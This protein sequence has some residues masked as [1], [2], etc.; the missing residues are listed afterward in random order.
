MSEVID[1]AAGKVYTVNKD[2]TYC[3]VKFTV[4]WLPGC[5]GFTEQAK[6]ALAATMG[7]DK[8]IIRGNYSILG[9]SRDPLIQEG[10]ALKRLL[11]T[12]RDTYTIPEYTLLSSAANTE[13]L[14]S[15]KVAGSYLIEAVKVEEFLTRFNEVREQYLAWGKRV[16]DPV[17]YNRIK[18]ADKTALGSDWDVIEAKYPTSF[19]LADSVTCDIPRI[20][21]FNASFTLSDVAPATAKR[22]AEQAEA[23]LMAS[24]EGATAEL[25]FEFKQMIEGVTRSCGR[26]VRL[27]PPLGHVRQDLRYAE[28][29]QIL[30]HIDEENVPEG[31]LL[32]TVQPCRPKDSDS[33]SYIRVGK[34]EDIL[35]TEA[36]YKNMSPFETDENKVLTQSSFDNLLALASK[37]SS[38]KSMLGGGS[39]SKDLTSLAE[40]VSAKLGSMGGSAAEIT[41]QLRNS[42]Y[43]R[44]QAK[45]TFNDFLTKITSQEIEVKS[46]VKARRKIKVGGGNIE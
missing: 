29:Q 10:A 3:S 26:R 27:L 23:R 25:V 30:R 7:V 34:E 5:L 45:A 1:V 16:A 36:E 9:S 20:E 2:V 46:R 32:V 43:A 42:S 35:V 14:R 6:S 4:G 28:V 21:P 31:S 18:D 15:A 11:I 22:L 8:R 39:E 38:V 37:I 24:V 44:Q 12:I 33:D 17:N 40:E 19:Y 13:E 41:K